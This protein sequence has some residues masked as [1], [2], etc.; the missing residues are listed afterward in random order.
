[1]EVAA[2]DEAREER[3]ERLARRVALRLVHPRTRW[4]AHALDDRAHRRLGDGTLACGE[5]VGALVAAD[6]DTPTCP[7]CFP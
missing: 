7:T 2:L 3:R 5:P 1:M 6:A 4:L